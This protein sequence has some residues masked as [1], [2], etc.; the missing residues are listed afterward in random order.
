MKTLVRP[1]GNLFD[2]WFLD[3]DISIKYENYYIIVFVS[4]YLLK[5]TN[6]YLVTNIE[7]KPQVNLE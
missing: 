5:F 6:M 2:C 4:L 3:I 7:L 1:L